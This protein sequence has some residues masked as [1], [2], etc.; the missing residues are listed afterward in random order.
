MPN[1]PKAISPKNI[2]KVKKRAFPS[3]VVETFNELIARNFTNG[4]AKVLQEDAVKL[5]VEKGLDRSEIFVKGWLNVEEIYEAEGWLVEYD[6]PVYYGG[7]NF[8]AYFT[9]TEKK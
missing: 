4:S 6:K 2:G 7:E 9:F 8:K 5:M 1:S 3:A